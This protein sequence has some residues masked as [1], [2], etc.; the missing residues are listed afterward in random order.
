LTQQ[1]LD[2]LVEASILSY[3]EAKKNKD[4][5]YQP[6]RDINAITISAVIEALE[7]NGVEDI[8]VA[9]T[10]K[11]GHLSEAM[12]TLNEE[13]EKSPANRLLKDI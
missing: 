9:R 5:S 8:P 10:A 6:A 12:K 2:E 7:Q 13:I 4:V 3:A 11:F 1:I